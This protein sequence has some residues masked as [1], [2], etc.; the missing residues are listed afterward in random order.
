MTRD[1]PPELAFD[2]SQAVSGAVQ[3]LKSRLEMS[4]LDRYVLGLSGGVDSACSA[5]LAVQAVGAERLVT[6]KMPARSSAEAS[7]RDAEAVEEALGVPADQRL[8]VEIGPLVDAWRLVAG[9]PDA[10]DGSLA[11]LRAGN[12]AARCR[13]VVLWDLALKHRGIVLGTENRT[14]NLL[15][16]FTIYGDSGTA[17]EPITSFYKSQVWELASYLGVPEQVVHKAPTADLWADQT[18]E[19]E[20][21]MRYQDADRVLHLVLDVGVSPED[22]P[23][24]TGLSED[25]VRRVVER[26]HATEFKRA[27]PYR[28]MR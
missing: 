9:V 13:M 25:V 24:R 21:G 10:V 17:V 14:E 1:L 11:A 15:G 22:A 3:F 20:L 28:H 6:V 8:L 26:Y 23:G 7:R 12:V 16:Y 4:G 27:I 18:D 19:S 2:V 5:A